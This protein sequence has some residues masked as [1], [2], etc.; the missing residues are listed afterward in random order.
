MFIKKC[1]TPVLLICFLTSCAAVNIRTDDQPK[2]MRPADYEKRYN[3]FW[4]GLKGKHQLN[5]RSICHDKGVEQMQT[6]HTLT[7]SV[8]TLFTLGIYEPRTARVWCSTT[9]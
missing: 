5:V 7:D 6:V 1:F 8:F 2:N 4:W 9:P 3:Y